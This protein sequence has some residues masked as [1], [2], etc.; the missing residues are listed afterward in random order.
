MKR[1][2]PTLALA[3]TTFTAAAVTFEEW[4]ATHF[5]PTELANPAISGPVANPDHDGRSN[6]LEFA[7]DADPKAFQAGVGPQVTRDANG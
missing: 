4:R 5:T 2:L 6:Y 3:A 7:F 1:L